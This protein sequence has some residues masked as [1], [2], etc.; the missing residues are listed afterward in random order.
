[1]RKAC[2]SRAPARRLVAAADLLARAE[3]PI[4]MGWLW[5]PR[6]SARLRRPVPDLV[7]AAYS[8]KSTLA[9]LIQEISLRLVELPSALT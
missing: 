3:K 8:M 9:L 2:R 7:Y 6:W 5:G 1:M 4:P